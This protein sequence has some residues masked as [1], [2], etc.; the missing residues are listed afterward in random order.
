MTETN[1]IELKEFLIL[2]ILY[3]ILVIG[4]GLYRVNLMT[5]I[6]DKNIIRIAKLSGTIS[7][8]LTSLF[9][10]ITIF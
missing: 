4:T 1:K 7:M 8:V 3:L 10:I 2:C 6:L 9:S 5:D